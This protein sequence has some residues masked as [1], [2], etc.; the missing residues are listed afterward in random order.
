MVDKGI[1]ACCHAL[2]QV[3]KDQDAT[4]YQSG[5]VPAAHVHLGLDAK[6]GEHQWLRLY[7]L[8]AASAAAG[9]PLM[10]LA[11]VL[12]LPLHSE[13][14]LRS[15][16]TLCSSLSQDLKVPG[17][18]GSVSPEGLLRPEAL[19]HAIYSPPAAAEGQLQL[20]G[21]QSE[22][23]L[24]KWVPKQ[25]GRKAVLRQDLQAALSKP[26]EQQMEA[27]R[28]QR[29]KQLDRAQARQSLQGLSLMASVSPPKTGLSGPC[30]VERNMKLCGA[31]LVNLVDSTCKIH[32]FKGISEVD[33]PPQKVWEKP[34]IFQRVK[35]A[36]VANI[37]ILG[38][39]FL[40]GRVSGSWGLQRGSQPPPIT[41]P[42]FPKA[43]VEH[44]ERAVKEPDEAEG[45]RTTRNRLTASN[46]TD[47]VQLARSV[48]QVHLGPA[49]AV[50][51]S[52]LDGWMR[53]GRRRWGSLLK[54][55][56]LE[57]STRLQAL[58][59]MQSRI[60]APKCPNC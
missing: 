12:S 53:R 51:G 9:T 54:R 16:L 36:C 25:T 30:K 32:T 24:Q 57:G 47:K 34:C 31:M 5:L 10:C 48:T 41:P 2:L 60:W 59:T 27:E 56:P 21:Q 19:Q 40:G 4:L 42:A 43:P 29:Q 23:E 44:D 14:S 13:L 28:E 1:G 17:G 3:L 55:G 8:S 11:T 52:T 15:V 22:G 20:P 45:E 38:E 26:I 46:A 39:Q 33:P 7:R 18:S 37:R 58:R 35:C 49:A 50:A 6:K